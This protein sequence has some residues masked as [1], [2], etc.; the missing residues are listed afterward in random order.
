MNLRRRGI[1]SISLRELPRCNLPAIN[2][3]LSAEISV[4]LVTGLHVLRESE[5]DHRRLLGAVPKVALAVIHE[6]ERR[7]RKQRTSGVRYT[8]EPHGISGLS[9]ETIIFKFQ[10]VI[11]RGGP[12]A[13]EA[14]DT[15]CDS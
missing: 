15:A 6:P 7:L 5:N 8:Q 12:A 4:E 1:P 11:V 9:G 13:S 14:R 3:N 10:E 2:E